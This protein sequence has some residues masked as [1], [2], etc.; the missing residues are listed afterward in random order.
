MCGIAGFISSQ[1]TAPVPAVLTAMAD[2]IR[3]RGP[4]ASGYY[5]D[6]YCGL[7]HRRLKIIDLSDAANQP[8]QDSSGDYTLIF[9]GEIYNYVYLRSELAAAGVR[10]KTKSDTEVLLYGLI[11][12]GEKFISKLEGD[13]AFCFRNKK[14]NETLLV[15][16]RFGVKPLYVCDYQDKLY[17]ASEIKSL[18]AAGVPRELETEFVAEYFRY[19]YVGRNDTLFKGIKHL[20]P[21]HLLKITDSGRETKCYYSLKE[22]TDSGKSFAASF[23][24]A[25]NGR[26]QADVPVG[27][28]LSG[29]ID[30]AAI[31]KQTSLLGR[32][33]NSFTYSFDRK[34]P[35]D[36]TETAK[37]LASELHFAHSTISG[38]DTGFTRYA[39]IIRTLEEPL[40]DS[41]I[42]ANY[43]LFAETKKQ[44]GVALSGE[45]A[46]EVFSSYAH[47]KVIRAVLFLRHSK[48]ISKIFSLVVRL[49][50]LELL[51]KFSPYPVK[52]NNSV[53]DRILAAINAQTD[54]EVF[55]HFASLF[56]EAELLNLLG[57]N[58]RKDRHFYED[59]V[60]ATD[61][62][63]W[64]PKYGLL[65]TDKLSMAYALEIRVPYLNHHLVQKAIST[66][67]FKTGMFEDKKGFR[68][69]CHKNLGMNAH[70]L[71]QKKRPFFN[72][73]TE[74]APKKLQFA[75]DILA[76][77][78]IAKFGILNFGFVSDLM[79]QEHKDFLWAKKVYSLVIFQ[80]WCEVFFPEYLK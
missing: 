71:K 74:I 57:K 7:A 23:R 19:R 8:M 73:E 64:L 41:I 79:N 43:E 63:N 18:F 62:K 60:Q 72:P 54:A 14:I 16:D 9:N 40:G 38:S 22:A 37:K 28:F 35:L 53:K 3:H 52:L 58:Y 55:Q 5:S 51:N 67:G 49:M 39:E 6:D 56:T 59:S 65:R 36:E 31:A 15:R 80:I 33:L 69:F 32:K 20:L 78:K 4:D 42:D 50:P 17:F 1:K 29:G 13:F 45:G 44:V 75:K 10:F 30:S 12:E 76:E 66:P 68:F 70:I 11:K 24:D 48:L 47:H 34:N 25:V 77:G 27:L 26:L 61:F 21:G 2:S 46:D